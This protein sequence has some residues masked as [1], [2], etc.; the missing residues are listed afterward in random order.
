MSAVSFVLKLLAV[1]RLVTLWVTLV[2]SEL[3]LM[4]E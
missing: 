4:A 1:W 3:V 2:G